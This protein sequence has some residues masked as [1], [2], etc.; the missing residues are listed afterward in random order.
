VRPGEKLSEELELGEECMTKTWH[1]KIFIGKISPPRESVNTLLEHLAGL[2]D[3][4]HELELR[5]CLGRL[6]PESQF[7]DLD[8]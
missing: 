2:S 3:G 1:S 7:S 5:R 6:L 4:E 8:A